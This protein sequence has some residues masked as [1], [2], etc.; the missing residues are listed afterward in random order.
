MTGK[1]L[2][3]L[4]ALAVLAAALA[5][6]VAFGG[7]DGSGGGH[8]GGGGGNEGGGRGDG[9]GGARAAGSHTVTLKNLAFHPG[10]L[11]ID[12]GDSVT[13]VWRDGTTEH[14]VTFHG[15]RSRTQAQGSYM[16]R[17][18]HTGTFSYECTLHVAEGMRGKIIV[19]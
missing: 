15:F 16:V 2:G 12:R 14:N 6:T 13:W 10:T 18:A 19:H 1:R 17:F 4:L 11:S 3:T 8:G 7:S 5:P 9:G